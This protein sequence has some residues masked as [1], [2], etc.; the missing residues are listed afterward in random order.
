MK[1]ANYSRATLSEF[2]GI[3]KQPG[4]PSREEYERTHFLAEVSAQSIRKLCDQHQK[5]FYC[6]KHKNPQFYW[7]LNQPFAERMGDP[8]QY[9]IRRQ[10]FTPQRDENRRDILPNGEKLLQARVVVHALVQYRLQAGEWIF[11]IPEEK[12]QRWVYTATR[13]GQE[14]VVVGLMKKCPDKLFLG[15]QNVYQIQNGSGCEAMTG[16]QVST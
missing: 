16:Y 10:P 9:L 5:L 13:I 12:S 14:L 2:E 1:A 3:G 11:S 4:L 15:L 8:G 7:C 6:D